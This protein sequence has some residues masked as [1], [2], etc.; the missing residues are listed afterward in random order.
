[1]RKLH[2]SLLKRIYRLRSRFAVYDRLRQHNWLLDSRN[3]LDQ[4]LIIRRPYEVKQIAKC[5]D[6]VGRHQLQ[7]F[8]D[9]GANFGL[10]S[11]LLSNESSLTEIHA[12]EPLLRNRHQLGANL[13]LNGL[14]WRVQ[15]HPYA[16][17]DQGG[18]F[19][20]F[21]DPK[22]T[23]VSTLLPTEMR[24][25]IGA[26]RE[27]VQ[28]EAR[29]FDEEWSLSGIRALVKIDVEGAELKVLGGMR[30]FIATNKLI[31]QIETTPETREGVCE[32][33]RQ[34][35]YGQLGHIGADYYFGNL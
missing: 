23:G 24:S 11:V 27:R 15:V 17:N 25:N 33:L 31:F 35:G 20:L 16:L 4:Q 26:Y 9:I 12:F 30:N 1:M 14:D 19:E 28:I 18:R 22:S 7:L 10:Y 29:V 2:W 34:S 6:F 8:F 21:V 13:F 5:R 3:W 32:I